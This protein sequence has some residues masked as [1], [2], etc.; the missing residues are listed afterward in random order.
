MIQLKI[1]K[2]LLY[3]KAFY[4]CFYAAG[5]SLVPFLPIYYAGLGFRGSQIGFLTSISPLMMLIS[6]PV[7]GAISDLT[8]RHKASLFLSIGGALTAV[9]ILSRLDLFTPIIIVVLIFAFFSSPIIPLVD[10][11]VMSLLES[12]RYLYGKQ[13][14]WGAVGWGISAPFIG[15]QADNLGIQWIFIGYL[16]WLGLGFFIVFGLPIKPV[17]R[18][19]SFLHNLRQL[20]SKR[21]W[22]LFLVTVY[23]SGSNLSIITNYL[24]LY[25]KEMGATQTLMGWGLTIATISEI[26]VLYFADRLIKRFGAQGVLILS[27]GASVVRAFGYAVVSTPLAALV[28][29]LFHGLTFSA[30]WAAGVSYASENAPPGLG[31]TAQS[32]FFSVV[33]GLSGITGG[34]LGGILFEKFGG[35]GMFVWSGSGVLIAL[36]MFMVFKHFYG[37]HAP[38][39]A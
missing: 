10:N 17:R 12:R 30:M 28:L 39:S 27:L 38:L 1:E 9:F 31:A 36:L 33:F 15:L 22:L 13:R 11:S 7:W 35:V 29:Q 2:N 26:P 23:I 24:F 34:F 8:Q 37:N 18:Q 21:E 20:I 5:A 3:A 19:S 25:L 16:F 4:F 32:V 6:T 14:M